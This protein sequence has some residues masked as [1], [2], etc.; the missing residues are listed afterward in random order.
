MGRPE[1]ATL[2]NLRQ[3][4]HQKFKAYLGHKAS[5]LVQQKQ[6]EKSYWVGVEDPCWDH[7][8]PD[9]VGVP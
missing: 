2:G 6:N 1:I 8:T 3:E 5:D 4:D 7:I 9:A